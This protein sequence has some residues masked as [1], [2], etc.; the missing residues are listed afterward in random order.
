VRLGTHRTHRAYRATTADAKISMGFDPN[1]QM[2]RHAHFYNKGGLRSFA[3]SAK[4]NNQREESGRSG[5][6]PEFSVVQT[7]RMAA[8]SPLCEF[9]FLAACACSVG[10]AA[11]A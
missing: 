3:A 10:N 11:S 4:S 9:G 5:Y 1:R 8:V 6:L 2:L 7:Q